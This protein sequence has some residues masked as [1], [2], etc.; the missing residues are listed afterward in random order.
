M[1]HGRADARRRMDAEPRRQLLAVGQFDHEALQTL[2]VQRLAGRIEDAQP[3]DHLL[4][5]LELT[6]EHA[7]WSRRALLVAAHN[8]AFEEQ[9]G[10]LCL[11]PNRKA[12]NRCERQHNS[13]QGFFHDVPP[14]P[15]RSNY[16]RIT[17]LSARCRRSPFRVKMRGTGIEH[18]FFEHMF[19]ARPARASSVGGMV[20]SHATTKLG[21]LL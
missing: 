16:S 6:V 11:R 9:L 14:A 1:I 15:P 18:M 7:A 2:V 12:A 8:I 5:M 4:Q 20:A 19:S 10:L 17:G 13:R 3:P 21:G